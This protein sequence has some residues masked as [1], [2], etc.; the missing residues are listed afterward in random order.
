M[1]ERTKQLKRLFAVA[2][3][4]AVIGGSA[5][6]P[7]TTS[8]AEDVGNGAGNPAAET[9]VSDEQHPVTEEPEEQG[10]RKVADLAKAGTEFKVNVKGLDE[11]I[12]GNDEL[13]AGYMNQLFYKGFDDGIATLGEVGRDRLTDPN[14][15]KIYDELKE[16]IENIAAGNVTATEDI[17]IPVSMTWTLDSLGITDPSDGTAIAGAV[18][19]RLSDLLEPVVSYLLMDCPYDF[20]WFDKTPG[21]GYSYGFHDL[22]SDG[23]G[24]CSLSVITFDFVVAEEYRE[25]QNWYELDTSKVDGVKKAS[26]AAAAIVEKYKDKPD[27]EK[28]DGYRKEICD[29]V[30]YNNNAADNALTPYG[31]PWQLI[32]VFDGDDSTNVVC[33]G[34]AKAFQYLCDLSQFSGDTICYTVTGTMDGGTGAGGHMW[35]IV[36]IG[37]KNYLVDVTNCDEG[38]IGADNKLF[39]AGTNRDSNGNYTFSISGMN[40]T[41]AYDKDQMSLFGA[42]I[43]N[44]ADEN[45]KYVK[46]LSL[47]ITPPKA[48]VTYGDS[49]DSSVLTGGSV[50][51]EN[52]NAVSGRFTWKGVTAYGEAGTKKLDVLF[53]P[54]D[55][56]QYDA[57]TVSADVTVQRKP[58]TVTADAKSKVYG[59]QDPELTYQAD[60]AVVAGDV[61]SGVLARDLGKDVR[62]GGYLI[63]QGTLTDENNPNYAITFK[64]SI[65]TI[66]P[67]TD[68]KETVKKEQNV[69]VGVGRFQEPVYTGVDSEAVEGDFTYTY[70]N[71]EGMDYASLVAELAKLELDTVKTIDYRF[72]PKDGGNYAGSKEG[73]IQVTVAAKAAQDS[74]QFDVSD[75]KKVYGDEDFT[76]CAKNAVPDSGVTYSS[77][78]LTVATVDAN[79]KVHILKKGTAVIT[80]QAEETDDYASALAS[81]TLTVSPKAL[82]W[83]VS[84]LQAV[85]KQGNITDKKASLYGE[86]RVSGILNADRAKVLFNCPADQL[87]GTYAETGVGTQ[88]VTLDWAGSPV[89][90]YGTDVENYTL[91]AS[92]P[93][94][95]GRINAVTEETNVPES[96]DQVKYKLE[97]ETG[98]SQVPP[99]LSANPEL[100]TPAKIEEKMEAVIRNKLEDEGSQNN[101]EVYDVVLM[102]EKEDGTWEKVTPENFPAD[103]IT[104]KLP[105]PQGTDKDTYNF[106]VAHMCT[107]EIGEYKPGDIEMPAVTKGDTD[108]QFKVKSLSPISLGW[109]EIKKEQPQ[110]PQKPDGGE[111]DKGSNADNS[112]KPTTAPKTG[113]SHTILLYVLFMMLGAAGIVYT[114]RR[115][116]I[117]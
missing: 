60:P 25:S 97:R 98:I 106:K 115:K 32:W 53:T 18:G 22:M 65:F 114:T 86:L 75:V 84:G 87:T 69:L 50:T 79:G 12:P 29:L 91:P 17:A 105:Y 94:I 43:L 83:D 57:A 78:D 36:T 47:K 117:R 9:Q 64:G 31:N 33:E 100:D 28:L 71:T 39:L 99:T 20:Y 113:D 81:Y 21:S 67:A 63:K 49:V 42:E 116:S 73:T 85:D 1:G 68:Y 62:A 103:G 101:I 37:G 24:N 88:K 6:L 5:N 23:K 4:L 34:Y 26:V 48:T 95:T 16:V 104:V 3:S 61:L 93:E 40:V 102:V 111:T 45:Y 8:F 13:F 52:G 107:V 77:S 10:S 59:A 112:K 2:L 89:G 15:L 110:Q 70:N 66:N 76:V 41:F 11:D 38:T 109:E 108:I 51:D 74:F 7:V 54:D 44:L 30:S 80:A 35:N 92:L 58:I 82:A 96:T 90:L 46:K 55:S 27:Y 19:R 14:Q 72:V 56:S